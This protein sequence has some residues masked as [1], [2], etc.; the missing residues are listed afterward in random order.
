M[1][2]LTQEETEDDKT[3]SKSDENIHH[4]N[5]IET[6]EAKTNNIRQR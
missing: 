4:I 6:I 3:S 2:R 5:E 1:K